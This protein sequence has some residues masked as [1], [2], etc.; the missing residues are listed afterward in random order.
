MINFAL[1]FIC[2]GIAIN[3]APWLYGVIQT[4]LVRARDAIRPPPR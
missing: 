1:G 3:R 2:G 4:W